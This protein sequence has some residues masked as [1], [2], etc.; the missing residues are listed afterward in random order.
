[1]YGPIPKRL[2][3]C[4]A[5]VR[6][7]PIKRGEVN[8]ETLQK[9]YD[10][11]NRAQPQSEKEQI[12]KDLLV[13]MNRQNPKSF[14]IFLRNSHL[15]PFVLWLHERDIVRHFRLEEAVLIKW[16]A[17]EKYYD[18]YI[19]RH[20]RRPIGEFLATPRKTIKKKMRRPPRQIAKGSNDPAQAAGAVEPEGA[21]ANEMQHEDDAPGPAAS[22][23]PA[24]PSSPKKGSARRALADAFAKL[25]EDSDDADDA[26]DAPDLRVTVGSSE[27]AAATTDEDE[28]DGDSKKKPGKV[29]AKPDEAKPDKDKPASEEEPEEESEEESE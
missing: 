8:E 27:D 12:Q 10:D 18:V 2:A 28:P 5:A 22:K 24:T 1:M 16:D 23:R 21:G 20:S 26:D 7:S 29:K 17:K 14:Q 11:I 4:Y 9:L 6:D 3:E 25:V 19:K 15:T 13:S